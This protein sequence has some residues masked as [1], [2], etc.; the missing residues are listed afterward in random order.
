MQITKNALKIASKML[1]CASTD[2]TRF[3]IQSLKIEKTDSV[4]VTR[5]IATDGH[6][7][8]IRYVQDETRI[9]QDL[10]LSRVDAEKPLKALIKELKKLP[11]NFILECKDAPENSNLPV[12]FEFGASILKAE[13]AHAIPNYPE[14]DQVIPSRTG[15]IEFALNAEYIMQIAQALQDNPAHKGLVFRVFDQASPVV[16]RAIADERSR[17]IGVIMPMRTNIM[18]AWPLDVYKA[19]RKAD[20][21]GE[22]FDAMAAKDQASA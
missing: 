10:F 8:A 14:V 11:E 5:F 17:D 7:L 9:S 4:G 2:V 3:Q 6:K 13:T 16:V 19:V 1:D 18:E 15:Y 20:K 21:V 22:A 12:R